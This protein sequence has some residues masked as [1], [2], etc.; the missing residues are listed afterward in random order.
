MWPNR[1]KLKKKQKKTKKNSKKII[2][3]I[4]KNS[5]KEGRVGRCF[6]HQTSGF[7]AI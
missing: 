3:K 5:Y 1:Y 4:I 2:K 7:I 6:Y